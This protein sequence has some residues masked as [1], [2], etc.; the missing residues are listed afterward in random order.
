SALP[1]SLLEELDVLCSSAMHRDTT[2]RY[3]SV[4]ALARDVDHFLRGEP[5]EA[6][7]DTLGYRTSKFLRRNRKA[8][9]AGGL[10]G[11]ALITLTAFYTIG[12]SR[13]RDR[14]TLEAERAQQ[15]SDYLIDLFETGDPY[16]VDADVADIRT[17]LARGE[18]RAEELAP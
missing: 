5:L 14:A 6:R 18:Q 12:I 16:A 4:E 11:I 8:T 13:E 17:L 15:V 7:P 10:A 1:R 2:R 9:I 3:G